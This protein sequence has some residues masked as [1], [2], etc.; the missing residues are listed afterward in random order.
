MPPRPARSSTRSSARRGRSRPGRARPWRQ[1]P[2]GA[3]LANQLGGQD[4]AQ[5]VAAITIATG[6]LFL[7]LA[8]LKLGWIAQFLSKAVITGFLAGAAIDVT[9]G[10]LPKLTGTSSSGDSSWRELWTWIQGLG[11]ISWTTLVVGLVSLGVILALRFTVPAVP[12]ALVLVVGGLLASGLFDLG[13]HGVALVGHVPR[14]LPSPALPELGHRSHSC[15]DD[16]HR[17]GRAAPDRVLADGRRCQGVRNQA[18]LPHRRQPGVDRAGD[19]ERGRRRLPGDA[20]LDEPLGKLAERV[21]GRANP[22]RVAD[23]RRP[24]AVDARRARTALLASSEGGARGGD[25]R[26][27]RV[28][29]D[30][31]RRA[32]AAAPGRAVRLLDR[33]RGDPRRPLGR[34]ARGRR[35]RRRPLTRLADLRR[36]L[37]EDAAA[38]P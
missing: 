25:H 37:A 24:R 26:R 23:H 4:A 1:W 10:E 20:G 7:L 13:A 8:L 33:G 21:G 12:G 3:V 2:A 35:G 38:R 14:G 31:H 34:G 17:L 29:D 27:G 30:R 22:G 32:A 9:I 6:V 28:R 36:D 18:P 5:L 19:G 11:D 16:R 15:P